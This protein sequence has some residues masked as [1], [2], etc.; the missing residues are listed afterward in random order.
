MPNLIPPAG[1]VSLRVIPTMPSTWGVFKLDQLVA[2]VARETL[3]VTDAY[4][5]GVSAYINA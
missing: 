2:S 4:F 5:V 1:D 3:W